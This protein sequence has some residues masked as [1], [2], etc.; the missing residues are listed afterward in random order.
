MLAR[1]IFA[2]EATCRWA[3]TGTPI[4]NRLTDLASLFRFL[5]VDPF[6]DPETFRLHV[7]Q[8]WKTRSDPQAVAK[9][10]LLIN[11][12]TLRRQKCAIDLPSR[13][14]EI[15]SLEFNP[16]ERSHYDDVKARTFG[17]IDAVLE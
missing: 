10:R 17:E 7:S 9:L 6:D 1:A 5:R 2:L 14:D 16:E 13:K 15:H 8:S 4:Q 3:V 11:S 12:I